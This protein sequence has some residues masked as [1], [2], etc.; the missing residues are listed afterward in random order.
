MLQKHERWMAQHRRVYKDAEEKA[1]R[2]NIFKKNVEYIES[3][4]QDTGKS[5]KL[6]V[7]AFA[8]L[9]T[10]EFNAGFGFKK[11][12]LQEMSIQEST[13]FRYGNVTNL[14]SN[15]DW[16]QKGVET[17]VRNQGKCGKS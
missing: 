8:D 3:F 4:N 5:Y 17:Y 10:E 7:N 14:P 15:V 2:F 9:T 12:A 11:Q 16:R 6:A 1:Q 13:P